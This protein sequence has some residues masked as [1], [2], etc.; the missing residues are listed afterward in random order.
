MNSRICF[1][2]YEKSRNTKLQLKSPLKKS[3]Y[4]ENIVKFA[5]QE[6]FICQIPKK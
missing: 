3:V 1:L 4:K 2:F 6:L 5:Q